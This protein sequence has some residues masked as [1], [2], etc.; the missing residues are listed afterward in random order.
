VEYD[1]VDFLYLRSEK[2]DAGKSGC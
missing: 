2:I 1:D